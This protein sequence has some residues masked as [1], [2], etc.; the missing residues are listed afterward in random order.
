MLGSPRNPAKERPMSRALKG[1]RVI[2][3]TRS[4]DE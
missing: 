1:I 2:D 4:F 3:I